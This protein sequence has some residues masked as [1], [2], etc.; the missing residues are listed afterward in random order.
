MC[1]VTLEKRKCIIN[2]FT[3]FFSLQIHVATCLL[4]K[5]ANRVDNCPEADNIAKWRNAS[6]RLNCSEYSGYYRI[7]T[8]KEKRLYHCLPSIF[9]NETIEFCG[10][11]AAIERGLKSPFLYSKTYIK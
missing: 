3:R 6:L 11:I 10:P 7:E 4:P 2:I 5:N 8:I 9:L 1:F